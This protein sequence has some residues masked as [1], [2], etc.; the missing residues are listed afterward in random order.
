M[1]IGTID[2]INSKGTHHPPILKEVLEYLKATDFS[3]MDEGSYNVENIGVVAKLQR[4]ETKP[5]EDCKAE[6]HTKF[7]DVQFVAEGEEALGW[8]PL[9]P[10][11]EVS[12]E[13]DSDKD[14]TFYAKLVPESCVVLTKGYFAILYPVDVHRPCCSLDDDEPSKVTKI[15]VKVPVEMLQ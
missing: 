5:V 2:N 4:Y 13:Y 7:I 1:F 14:V 15:V 6:T 10:D 11:L 8:C 9:S 3:K 12:E